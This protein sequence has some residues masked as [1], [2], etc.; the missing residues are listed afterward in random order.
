MPTLDK[1]AGTSTNGVTGVPSSVSSD[2]AVSDLHVSETWITTK[3]SVAIDLV[4]LS[5]HSGLTR[6][7]SLATVQVLIF[8]D[9]YVS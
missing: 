8:S 1:E 4:E 6:D 3:I 5:L 7:S 9:G 2:T